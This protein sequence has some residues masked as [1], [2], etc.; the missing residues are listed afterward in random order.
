MKGF[1]DSHYIISKNGEVFNSKTNRYLKPRKIKGG[2]VR[3]VLYINK[4]KIEKTVHRLVAELYLPN[5]E[6]K[7]EVNHINNITD[8][9][10]VEN[11]EWV[12][13]KENNQHK[14]KQLR[15]SYGSKAVNSKL[16]ETQV[17]EIVEL[18]KN[19]RLK[20]MEIAKIYNV[21]YQSISAISRNISWK[22]INSKGVLRTRSDNSLLYNN[23]KKELIKE[24]YKLNNRLPNVMSKDVEEK[25]LFKYMSRYCSPSEKL[26]DEDF[27]KWKQSVF[28]KKKRAKG[29]YKTRCLK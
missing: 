4:T 25:R 26:Y 11:L 5:P 12:T 23:S 9:N 20:I 22:Y 14:V 24:F 6:N 15:H 3:V 21:R 10:R 28:V 18:L 17:L 16:T 2:Y 7:P 13:S 29:P 19:T 27:K 1:M 8:D